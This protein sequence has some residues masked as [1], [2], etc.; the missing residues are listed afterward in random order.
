MTSSFVATTKLAL[1]CLLATVSDACTVFIAGKEATTDG[2]VLV[3]AKHASR[4][5]F[6]SQLLTGFLPS[7]FA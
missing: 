3:S 6:R 4:E 7:T 2:S 5:Q 1:A